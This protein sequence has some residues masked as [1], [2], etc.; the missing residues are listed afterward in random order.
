MWWESGP[1]G[2]AG[3]QYGSKRLP[4]SSPALPVDYVQDAFRQI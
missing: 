1:T 2:Y 3:R 4:A